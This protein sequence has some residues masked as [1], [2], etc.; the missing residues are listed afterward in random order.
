METFRIIDE[1]RHITRL[2]NV[3]LTLQQC[4]TQIIFGREQYF[5]I[6]KKLQRKK[7][8]TIRALGSPYK[9][10]KICLKEQRW[11]AIEPRRVD[12]RPNP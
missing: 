7:K 6:S 4:K 8:L 11:A 3:K 12:I 10:L 9:N 2:D 5:K 1:K